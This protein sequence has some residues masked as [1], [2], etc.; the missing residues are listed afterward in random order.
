MVIFHSYVSL[1]EGNG[2]YHSQLYDMWM[3]LK[4]GDSRWIAPLF[5]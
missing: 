3:C 4:I 2:V 1:P 5:Q